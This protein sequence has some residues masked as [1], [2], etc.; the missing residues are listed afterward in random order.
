MHPVLQVFRQ[1]SNH[2]H[3]QYRRFH[4]K[5]RIKLL[6]NYDDPDA[7]HESGQHRIGNIPHI[8]ADFQNSEQH[9]EHAAEQSGHRHGQ[10][11]LSKIG[12]GRSR[13][14]ARHQSGGNNSHRSRRTADLGMGSPEQRGKKAQHGCA[15]QTGQRPNGSRSRIVNAAKCLNTECQSQGQCHDSRS[16]P[17]EK[18][19]FPFFE[20]N[21][22]QLFK[23]NTYKMQR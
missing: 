17:T 8:L 9:L 1:L 14:H 21:H 6:Q 19:P 11:N 22:F 23:N 10:Q 18:I 2:I 16:N 13:P 20:I 7:A 4:A 5:E 3:H 12:V 15:H